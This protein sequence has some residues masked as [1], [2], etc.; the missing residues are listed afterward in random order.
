MVS[1]FLR[2]KLKTSLTGAGYSPD[3][4]F[5][6]SP[7]SRFGDYTTNVAMAAAALSGKNSRGV[8]DTLVK[9]L[10]RNEEIKRRVSK[11]EIAGPGFINFFLTD[12]A[13]LDELNEIKQKTENGFDFLKKDGVAK[14]INI[15][16]ISAN[17]TGALHIGHGRGAFYGDILANIFSFA[18]ARVVR[19]YYIN[20]SRE[21]K[22]IIELGKTALGKGEQYK[23]SETEELISKNDF[24]GMSEPEAGSKLSGLIQG[25]NRTFIEKKIKILGFNWYSEDE[26]LRVSKLNDKVLADL[27]EEKLTYEKDG[28][29]W[30]KTSEYGD[31]EDR[32]VVR[33]DGTKSYFLSD[34]AY[35]NDKFA[36][37][38]DKI[39]D[40]WGADHHGHV[41][42]IEAVKKM[43]GWKG[44]LKIFI[45]Q[46]VSLKENGVSSKMSKRAGNVILLEDLV[47]EFGLDVVRWFFS[48]KSLNT[49]MEFDME[50]AREHSAKNPVSYVQYAHAR[51]SSILEKAKNIPV[52]GSNI[53]DTMKDKEA[54]KLAV[55]IMEFPEV[56]SSI[57]QDYQVHKLTTYLY[58]LASAF[59]QFYEKVRI[60]GDTSHNSGALELATLTKETIALSLN[61][62]GISAPERM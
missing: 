23:T 57:A 7:E 9:D 51:I 3:A 50:L 32:V 60:I 27:E 46:L 20:D 16:F 54:R 30:L 58:G 53:A 26:K 1:D 28:A 18:G 45:T 4:R 14:K 21:S 31:D 55:K 2:D 52:D 8:A 35:H 37:G 38:Y 11:I 42:R 56:V 59:A 5:D 6:V 43:L 48:D 17:P 13:I 62:L 47:D 39:I 29:V 61:L 44:E 12:T 41:K 49:H 22:Q 19:E 40:I 33:S 34:I 25:N 36:G 10:E 24:S 15:E